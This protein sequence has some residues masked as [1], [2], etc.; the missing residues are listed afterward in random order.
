MINNYLNLTQ[1]V[2]FEKILMSSGIFINFGWFLRKLWVPN[3]K[4]HHNFHKNNEISQIFKQ[5]GSLWIIICNLK[6]FLEF[7]FHSFGIYRQKITSFFEK[8]VGKSWFCS[9]IGHSFSV[10]QFPRSK[11]LRSEVWQSKTVLH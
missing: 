11:V 5:N 1:T 6:V 2:D 3:K 9:K 10:M 4:N 7:Q 8:K